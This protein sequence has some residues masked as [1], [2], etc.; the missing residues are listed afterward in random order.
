[1]GDFQED[2]VKIGWHEPICERV[3]IA[4]KRAHTPYPH[5][6]FCNE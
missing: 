6:G 2:R 4:S 5:Q 3:V 1:M